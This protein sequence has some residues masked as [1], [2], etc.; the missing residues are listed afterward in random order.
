MQDNISSAEYRAQIYMLNQEISELNQQLSEKDAQLRRCSAIDKH[1]PFGNPTEYPGYN[2]DYSD[3]VPQ[4]DISG[5]RIPVEPHRGEKKRLRRFYTIGGSCVAFHFA[6][7]NLVAAGL[8]GVVMIILQF[9]NPTVPYE[10][11][12]QYAYGSSILISMNVIAY[13][14]ANVL[15]AY[16]GIRWSKVGGASLIRTRDFTAGKAVQY[17]LAGVFIQY[18]AAMLSTIADDVLSK[19]GFDSTVDSSGLGTTV[20]A[21]IISTIYACII[22]P[23][24]EELFYRGMLL[25]V[26]SRASQRFAIYATAFIFGLAH[27][28]IPQF[29]LAF[30]LGIFLAHISVKHN[31]LLPSVLVHI[32]VNLSATLLNTVN[33]HFGD[34]FIIV[35]L[36]GILYILI[37]I[38][39]LVMFI[40]FVLKS[41][42]PKNTP[43]QSRRGFTVAK[44]S[45]PLIISVV[46]LVGTMLL[47]M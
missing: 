16:I 27:G 25:K 28:N 33:T 32:F 46:L 24:T 21:V 37:A 9:M 10:V 42:V 20:P 23:I 31:S 8:V 22:A 40:T 4:I 13:L 2:G 41:K 12:Y 3:I 36:A 6:F 1:D 38:A 39:G 26:F 45:I 44:T 47:N 15:F 17:C 7:I 34:N 14:I 18:G 43:Q 35:G 29:I 19:Y 11:L 5:C 30:L